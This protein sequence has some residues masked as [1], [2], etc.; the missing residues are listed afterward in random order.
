VLKQLTSDNGEPVGSEEYF[1]KISE[2][3]FLGAIVANGGE[4]NYLSVVQKLPIAA[5]ISEI[6]SDLASKAE[7]IP[8]IPKENKGRLIGFLRNLQELSPEANAEPCIA[9]LSKEANNNYITR[10]DSKIQKIKD[11]G[12]FGITEKEG[13]QFFR[14]VVSEGGVGSVTSIGSKFYL[15]DIFGGEDD[16]MIKDVMTRYDFLKVAK[17]Y[18]AACGLK[19]G[20]KEHIS[21]LEK[22]LFGEGGYEYIKAN[23][24]S[25]GYKAMIIAS[26][27]AIGNRIYDD[28]KAGEKER[29]YICADE[30]VKL[31]A[32]VSGL[33]AKNGGNI[34]KLVDGLN[35]RADEYANWYDWLLKIPEEARELFKDINMSQYNLYKNIKG[36]ISFFDWLTYGYLSANENRGKVAFDNPNLYNIG[37]WLTSGLFDAIKGTFNP[38]KPLS[39]QHWLDSFVTFYFMTVTYG[40]I[41][42]SSNFGEKVKPKDSGTKANLA[43]VGDDFGKMGKLVEHPGQKANWSNITTHGTERMAHRGVTQS[44]VDNWVSNGKVLKQSSG[45][46]IY[47]TKEGAAVLNSAGELVTTYPRANFDANMLDI[48]KQL[49]G[50]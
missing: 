41:K 17:N 7:V 30:A 15:S 22:K 32:A 34:L 28:L 1:R 3:T 11:G 50:E 35:K 24:K 49:F 14:D 19:I 25:G 47:I 42:K 9:L 46:H 18:N 48:V 27:N 29:D 38:E 8:Y 2:N 45:N 44:M 43:K 12:T 10:L 36:P 13:I 33:G 31:K 23:V 6:A 26:I 21:Y 37:N 40:A 39:L 20:S 5:V 4:I 16:S